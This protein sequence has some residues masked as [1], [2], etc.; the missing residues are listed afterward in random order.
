MSDLMS[1]DEEFPIEA[2]ASYLNLYA[3]FKASVNSD[4]HMRKGEV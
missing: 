3:V 1:K 2:A 4:T